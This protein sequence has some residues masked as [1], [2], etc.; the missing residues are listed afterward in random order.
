[1][2]ALEEGVGEAAEQLWYA[3]A[4]LHLASRV[5]A[6]RRRDPGE[7]GVFALAVH[8]GSF[9]EPHPRMTMDPELLRDLIKTK[10]R[11]GALPYDSIPRIWGGQSAGEACDACDRLILGDQMV[12]E[13]IA[14]DG[15]RKPLQLH[16]QCFGLW[17]E[18]RRNEVED[19]P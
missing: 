6:P 10:L 7:S 18:E 4:C 3:P 11:S 8:R 2:L 9:D 12:M 19:Q 5:D 15:G 14:L 1:M 13:G 17:D 16:V